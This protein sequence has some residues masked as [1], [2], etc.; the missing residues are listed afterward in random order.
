MK[1]TF[2]VIIAL[3][4]LLLAGCSTIV[5][6]PTTTPAPTETPVPVL[7]KSVDDIIGNWRIVGSDYRPVFVQFSE[8]GT[9]R[10]ASAKVTNLK[11]APGQQG[12]FMLEGGLLT[13]VTSSESA[14]CADQIGTWEVH[15]FEEGRI[16]LFLDEDECSLREGTN[17]S[18]LEEPS[19]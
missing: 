5:L 15:L 1:K 16:G 9:Y 11:D 8:D 12:Q 13:F 3:G 19:P 10:M 7:A 18:A 14:F 2:T 4:A 6:P 17:F